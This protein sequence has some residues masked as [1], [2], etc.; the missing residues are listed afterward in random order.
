M[1]T[2]ANDLP[3]SIPAPPPVGARHASYLPQLDGFRALAVTAVM[4]DH[5]WF[6]G[7]SLGHLGV[8]LFFVLSGFLITAGLIADRERGDAVGGDRPG[9]L[10]RFYARRFLR[11]FPP[12]YL[13]VAIMALSVPEVAQTLKWHLLYLTNL[14][15]AR[16]NA[17]IPW[18]VGHFWSLAVEEQFYLLWPFVVLLAPRR[19]LAHV[20]IGVILLS[21]VYRAVALVT[22]LEAMQVSRTVLPFAAIDAL[23][24]GALLALLRDR[25]GIRRILL[26]IAL[27]GAVAWL[28]LA[29]LMG[30]GLLGGAWVAVEYLV[31][32]PLTAVVFAGAVAWAQGLPTGLL[33]RLVAAWPLRSLGRISYG[34]YL[35]H[36][37]IGA[38]IWHLQGSADYGPLHALVSAAASIAAATLSWHLLERPILRLKRHFRGPRG[39]TRELAQTSPLPQRPE[40]GFLSRG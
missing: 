21:L 28:T 35:Y 14:Y 8:R 32:Q 34:V 33:S 29:W 12:Y 16:H 20:F 15:E 38:L 7:S 26:W 5:F 24:A 4:L 27:A 22:P 18:Q 36:M 39:D 9:I 30:G 11:I 2:A 1:A 6:A 25:A 40:P 23:A 13:L 31:M 10:F 17:F 19:W 37:P 3:P